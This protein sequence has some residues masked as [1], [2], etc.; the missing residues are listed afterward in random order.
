MRLSLKWVAKL[1]RINVLKKPQKDEKVYFVIKGQA[2]SRD[3]TLALS[4]HEKD[5]GRRVSVS[6]VNYDTK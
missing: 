3:L 2:R 1:N 4:D 5:H 6:P